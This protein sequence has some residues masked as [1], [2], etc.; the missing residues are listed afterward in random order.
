M[1]ILGISAYYHDS[2][3]A[4]VRDGDIVPAAQQERFSRKKHD[5]SFPDH[6]VRYCLAEGG[7][8]R[9]DLDAVV[10]YDKPLTK[11]VRI[12]ETAFAV[13]VTYLVKTGVMDLGVLVRAMSENPTTAF[14]LPRSARTAS[15]SLWRMLTESPATGSPSPA[16]LRSSSRAA[17][18]LWT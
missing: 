14:R 12:L 1:N 15:T 3:A 8:G 2:A 10:F 6:A 7:V 5:A 9:G 17:G 4:L 11:F 13:G 18:L 16:R